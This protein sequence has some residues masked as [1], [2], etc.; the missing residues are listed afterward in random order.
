M[1][2]N[3]RKATLSWL[4]K[5]ISCGNSD[6]QPELGKPAATHS[7][8][9]N[10]N[11]GNSPF[12]GSSFKKQ[13]YGKQTASKLLNVSKILREIKDKKLSF[14]KVD[15]WGGH[16]YEDN[17]PFDQSSFKS[18][19]ARHSVWDTGPLEQS[20]DNMNRQAT[21]LESSRKDKEI[22]NTN[23][24]VREGIALLPS[25]SEKQ[26]KNAI[27]VANGAKPPQDFTQKEQLFMM[28]MAENKHLSWDTLRNLMPT[29]I[30]DTIQ[31]HIDAAGRSAEEVKAQEIKAQESQI[32]AFEQQKFSKEQEEKFGM[33]ELATKQAIYAKK[34]QDWKDNNPPIG[35]PPE[36][37]DEKTIKEYIAKGDY[38]QTN[39]GGL[40]IG[41]S[42]IARHIVREMIKDDKDDKKAKNIKFV[43]PTT[44]EKEVNDMFQQIYADFAEQL[45]KRKKKGLTITTAGLPS[46]PPL[47][48]SP[49]PSLPVGPTPITPTPLTPTTPS[50]DDIFS[51]GQNALD[52]LDAI[53]NDD[54][55]KIDVLV[56][57]TVILTTNKMGNSIFNSKLVR[58]KLWKKVQQNIIKL[59]RGSKTTL[60]LKPQ[61]QV[62]KSHGLQAFLSV[63]EKGVPE[64]YDPKGNPVPKGGLFISWNETTP[65]FSGKKNSNFSFNF[66]NLTF[67]RL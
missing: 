56:D 62:P 23:N 37:S 35:F 11:K 38:D 54:E 49:T 52:Y 7:I 17:H 24:L 32:E 22:A 53:Q 66:E 33:R 16:D 59:N 36:D 50:D 13:I 29:E 43:K 48:P 67:T 57:E 55:K 34:E 3:H 51:E 6:I 14:G 25:I 28:R 63:D 45:K 9:S 15:R 21:D 27:A 31:G 26:N 19:D 39:L 30:K 47:P 1:K 58:N 2:A 5:Q 61:K 20:S 65:Y 10:K 46:G 44:E 40:V 41:I 42:K 64:K 12:W 60:G 18:I 8:A 4:N